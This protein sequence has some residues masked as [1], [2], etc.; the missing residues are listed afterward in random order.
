MRIYMG[1]VEVEHSYKTQYKY[2]V[3]DAFSDRETASG[4]EINEL[5][6]ANLEEWRQRKDEIGKVATAR[7]SAMLMILEDEKAV[8][9]VE[10][11]GDG[12]DVYTKA[13]GYY[14]VLYKTI[15]EL[16]DELELDSPW[17]GEID[18]STFDERTDEKY[19]HVEVERRILTIYQLNKIGDYLFNI[20]KMD[21]IE[22][23]DVE[24]FKSDGDYQLKYIILEL[25][26]NCR[27][28][29]LS[30]IKDH[31]SRS[32]EQV[33]SVRKPDKKEDITSE[34]IIS[35]LSFLEETKALKSSRNSAGEKT[36]S[37]GA[38]YPAQLHQA[39]D[40]VSELISLIVSDYDH[41]DPNAPDR[42]K[43]GNAAIEVI[44]SDEQ[45]HRIGD[46]LMAID[47]VDP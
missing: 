17:S 33:R 39:C 45:I 44:L 3:L 13:P 32:V 18:W 9:F 11:K 20:G 27:D 36:Y 14:A 29:P 10:E 43:I 46:Y 26:G 2:A 25:L 7:T 19:S 37:K 4:K 16:K 24:I 8:S 23:E 42:Y 21:E 22:P 30:E 47:K 38:V 6:D 1:D 31:V 15:C 28:V 5:I 34:R 40:Q 12:D 41:F 35:V